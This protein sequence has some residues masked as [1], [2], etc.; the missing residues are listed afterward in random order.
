MI[1]EIAEW[2]LQLDRAE[3]FLLWKLGMQISRIKK[4]W[5]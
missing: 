1:E 2:L 3:Y 5:I 4:Y